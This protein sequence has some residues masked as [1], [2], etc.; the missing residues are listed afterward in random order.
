MMLHTGYLSGYEDGSFAPNKSMTR[1]EAISMLNRIEKNTNEALLNVNQNTNELIQNTIQNVNETT[2]N[3]ISEN[4][5]NHPQNI[6][7]KNGDNG[8]A[9]HN[10]KSKEEKKPEKSQ[11]SPLQKRILQIFMQRLWKMMLF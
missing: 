2:Q 6:I 4:I 7:W 8:N 5:E 11:K 3:E 10:D 9:Y 1:A